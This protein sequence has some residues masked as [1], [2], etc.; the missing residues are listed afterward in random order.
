MNILIKSAKIFG[1]IILTFVITV[2]AQKRCNFMAFA[3]LKVG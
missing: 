2:V 1:I 3:R